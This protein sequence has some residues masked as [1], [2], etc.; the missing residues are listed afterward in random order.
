MKKAKIFIILI[1]IVMIFTSCIS[2]EDIQAKEDEKSD[3]E[4]D[5][6]QLE[7]TLNTL[8]TEIEEST[9]KL[10]DAKTENENLSENIANQ[11]SEN[12]ELESSIHVPPLSFYDTDF[13]TRV[14]YILSQKNLIAENEDFYI[15]F[16]FDDNLGNDYCKLSYIYKGSIENESYICISYVYKKNNG[17][18]LEILVEYESD[19]YKQDYDELSVIA[20]EALIMII[21][22]PNL[23]IGDMSDRAKE[24]IAEGSYFDGVYI[25][26]QTET[27]NGAMTKIYAKN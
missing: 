21:E 6:S 24:I 26:E 8:K 12:S 3:L 4:A 15:D 25:I 19:E 23:Y 27:E 16:G 2:K 1:A 13:N 22:H 5:Y 17:Y 14:S 18:F 7:D 9:Q 20:A 11:I 10:S